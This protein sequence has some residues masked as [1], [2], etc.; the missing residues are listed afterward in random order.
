[1]K[2]TI[3]LL[4]CFAFLFS[5]V[6]CFGG[7]GETPPTAAPDPYAAITDTYKALLL[8]KKNGE[9]LPPAVHPLGEGIE[10][11]LRKT[12]ES[13]TDPDAMGYALRDLDKNGT[14]ELIL[15][16]R[17]CELSALF[18]LRDGEPILL[19]ELDPWSAIDENGTVY[20]SASGENVTRVMRVAGD[21]MEGR[22]FGITENEDG[23]R[24]PFHEVNGERMEVDTYDIVQLNDLVDNALRTCTY[25]TKTAGLRF[26]SALGDAAQ[27]NASVPDAHSYDGILALYRQAVSLFADFDQIAWVEGEYDALYRFPDNESYEVYHAV[28]YGAMR[29]RPTKVRFNTAIADGAENAYGYA[30]KDLD[31]DGGEELILL[32]DRYAVL[33]VFTEKNGRAVL[34][35][36]AYGARI[37]ESGALTVHN[38]IGDAINRGEEHCRYVIEDGALVAEK[39]LWYLGKPAATPIFPMHFYSSENGMKTEI[40][41]TEFYEMDDGFRAPIGYSDTEYTR[42]FA[43]LH[44]VPLTRHAEP[45]ECKAGKYV[46]SSTVG[47]LNLTLSLVTE[48]SLAFQWSYASPTLSPT[49]E[50]ERAELNGTAQRDGGVYRFEADGVKGYVELAVNG[51]WV[52]VTESEN[53]VIPCRAYL[54]NVREA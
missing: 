8:A 28:L 53:E 3:S 12:V 37:D 26:I 10:A 44:Y 43:D 46:S 14:E 54:Y 5:L 4:L 9:E 17:A 39:R 2:K 51:A 36:G 41:P 23:S 34:L 1:M 24:T 19:M 7:G 29:L 13:C 45:S 50:P 22:T 20:S 49:D 27:E 31:G 40:T 38:T 42:N 48:A 15:L 6:G 25:T 52:V 21:K 35:D 33:A 16:S 11:V 18:T 32:T 47:G 30:K